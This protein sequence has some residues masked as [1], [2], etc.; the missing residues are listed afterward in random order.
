M[1]SGCRSRPLPGWPRP[2]LA[3]DRGRG[4]TPVNISVY[5]GQAG[6]TLP[7]LAPGLLLAL[8]V[9]FPPIVYPFLFFLLLGLERRNRQNI[10]IKKDLVL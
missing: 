1:G 10:L 2:I 4:G 7:V 6:F 5:Q 9:A 3:A 8:R